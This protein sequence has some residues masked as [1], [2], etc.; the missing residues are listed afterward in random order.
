MNV[1]GAEV[2]H[3]APKL[4]ARINRSGGRKADE[5]M[6]VTM[7]EQVV[8]QGAPDLFQGVMQRYALKTSVT[9]PLK[10]YATSIT[11]AL[12]MALNEQRERELLAGELLDLEFA[13]REA[14]EL[15]RIAD[16]LGSTATDRALASLKAKMGV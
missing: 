9:T 3:V 12:E 1:S 15:A 16:A 4:L 2:T 10:D 14:E 11:L 5:R 8:S 13:W 7:L 6:A